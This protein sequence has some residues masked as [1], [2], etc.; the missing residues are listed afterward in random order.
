M[1]QSDLFFGTRGPRD[2]K[3]MIIA[4][5]WGNEE[6]KRQLPLVGPSGEENSRLFAECNIDESQCLFTNIISA[7]P[8]SNDMTYFFH[9]NAEVKA[10]NCGPCI[11][12][13]Y[14]K[15]NVIE[16]L[17]K[18]ERLIA[19][20]KPDFIIGYGNYTLWALTEDSF[21]IENKSRRMGE[22]TTKAPTGIGNWRGS[23]LYTRI[24]NIPFMPTYH[25]AAYLREWSWRYL[26]KHDLTARRAK[27]T[28]GK[29]P[30]P[31]YNLT[32]RPSRFVAWHTL[33]GLKLR[34]CV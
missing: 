16:G 28:Q 10:G 18:L 32:I 22:P 25:P 11:R 30:K 13:L 12:G 29:W 6:A 9:N 3:L 5:S 33:Q 15:P 2:A 24:T 23:Q 7:Q 17:A 26:V 34:G 4:E 8:P 31:N 14:P 27:F 20:V 1:T 21:S 19:T